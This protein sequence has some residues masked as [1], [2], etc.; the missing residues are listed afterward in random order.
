MHSVRPTVIVAKLIMK[1]WRIYTPIFAAN[2]VARH[3]VCVVF[4][5]HKYSSRPVSV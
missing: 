5:F 3:F 1:A 4:P 2:V